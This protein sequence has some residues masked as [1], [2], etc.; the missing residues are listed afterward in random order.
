MAKG[1]IKWNEDDGIAENARKRLPKI[2]A[3]YFA[4]VRAALAENPTAPEMHRLRL[5]S[6]HFRYTL[7]LFKH[8]YAAGVEERIDRLKAVQDMLGD[9]NDAV[10][11]APRVEKALKDQPAERAHMRKYLEV[12]AEQ[13][14]AE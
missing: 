10:A 9:C 7:E 8:C 6:K 5:A 1:K 12:L 3:D 11:S 14:T 2:A 13:K 4:E